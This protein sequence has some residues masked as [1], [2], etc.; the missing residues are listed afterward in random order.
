M[1][2]IYSVSSLFSEYYEINLKNSKVQELG[3]WYKRE[4]I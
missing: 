1:D 4:D 3:V 2:K